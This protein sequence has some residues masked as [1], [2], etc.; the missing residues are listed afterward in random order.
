MNILWELCIWSDWKSLNGLSFLE[1]IYIK[2]RKTE[3]VEISKLPR[4]WIQGSLRMQECRDQ[5]EIYNYRRSQLSNNKLDS[6]G[7]RLTW[8]ECKL[9]C[10]LWPSCVFQ[11]VLHVF[12]KSNLTPSQRRESLLMVNSSFQP[13]F[14][15]KILCYCK[16]HK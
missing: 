9:A 1:D 15:T 14:Q 2:F 12:V 4:V 10:S 5:S 13:F 16:L 7:V 11:L 6:W 8:F 3:L